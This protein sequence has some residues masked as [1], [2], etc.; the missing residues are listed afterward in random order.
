MLELREIT[1]AYTTASLTQTAL[2]QVSV[3]FRDNEFVAILGQSGSGKTT[4]LNVIGGLDHFDSGDLVIDGISTRD[5]KNRDW[6]TYR[7][8]RIG[9]VFQ[10]YNLIPHQTVLSNVEL[11]LTLSGVG[12]AERQSRAKDALT[13]VGLA[14]HIHKKPNQLSGGQMQRVAIARALVNDPEI[15]LADEP[16]GAL[17]SSTSVQVMDLL[18]EV[19][20][21]RLVIMVTHNPELAHR[22]ATRIVELA[23]GQIIADTAPFIPGTEEMRVAREARRT[24]MSFLTALSLSFTNLMTKKGRTLMTSF[25]GSIGIIGI[26]AILALANG[27]NAY[28]DRTEE[29]ML[30]SYPLVIRR[31]NVDMTSMLGAFGGAQG[32]NGDAKNAS[33]TQAKNGA[34]ADGAASGGL[35]SSNELEKVLGS[36]SENDLKALRTYFSANGGN[37]DEQVRAIEYNYDVTPQIYLPD[38]GKGKEPER[39]NPSSLLEDVKMPAG[40]PPVFSQNLTIEAF[41]ELPSESA[42][43]SEDYIVETGRWPDKANELV[44]VL[45]Q[46]GEVSDV[47]EFSLGLRDSKEIQ[48]M[49]D[50]SNKDA[51]QSDTQAQSADGQ[52]G[53]QSA[54]SAQS[55]APRKY[56]YEDILAVEYR[57][58]DISGFYDWDKERGIWADHSD[59][60]KRTADLVAKGE[61]LNIV[62]IMRTKPGVDAPSLQ[63]GLYYTDKLTEH[64][65]SKAAQSKIV[66]EQR[67]NPKRNV[68]TGKD[69]PQSASSDPLAGFDMA[70]LFTID[71]AKIQ[72][73]FSIDEAALS[74]A[75]GDID[76]SGM[77]LSGLE[78]I[79]MEAPAMDLSSLD[80]S[81]IDL[82]KVNASSVNADSL[83]SQ[84]PQLSNVDWNKTVNDA[85]ADGAIKQDAGPALSGL[86]QELAQGFMQYQAANT[87]SGKDPNALAVEY[88]STEPVTKRIQEVLSGPEVIDREKIGAN[89][90]KSLGNDPAVQAAGDAV[91][92]QIVKVLVQEVGTYV[93]DTISNAISSQIQQMM[94]AYMGQMMQT[95]EQEISAQMEKAAANMGE[96][97]TG[98]MKVDEKAISE[99]FSMNKEGADLTAIFTSMMSAQRDSYESN[100]AKLGYAEVENPST[101]AIYPHSF[102]AKE[103][104][105]TILADYN[106]AQQDAGYEK[107]V[108]Q[109][110]DMVGLVMSQV[111]NIVGAVTSMLIAFVGISLVVSS[112]MIGII[113]YIS[114][115]ERKKEIGILRSIGASRGDIRSVFNAETVLIG[116]LAGL[117]GVVITYLL[118]IPANI[119]VANILNIENIAQ[120]PILAAMLL[121]VISVG[122]TFMAGLLPAG[123]AAK[124]D[125]VEALRSE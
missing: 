51:A 42:I 85:L 70:S 14:D 25:A 27:V 44:L 20:K 120:L 113:T 59:D 71:E 22:Y 69:F 29:E 66:Q 123:K 3:A 31:S 67:K 74:E 62:G 101:I 86:S 65:M 121:I 75:M 84:F 80:L 114:V 116:L 36:L 117:L 7:N 11:A 97:F 18:K 40:L 26:A 12:R 125:P 47:F 46:D 68:F 64:V 78:S 1:K 77:D 54:E 89:L 88:F 100:L 50:A 107:R 41:S 63:A 38:R 76:L 91:A 19:A 79:P 102:Q 2:N 60:K 28:I 93:G 39:V 92:D 45:P 17:D 99:A 8:N 122:L 108:I 105:K 104:V 110:N 87:G 61:K 15:L 90:T 95:L 82:S 9:F 94:T 4:M 112:I 16:T 96:A 115:L 53:S 52:S 23:D 72:S 34:G 6:D 73:A 43:Y 56:T 98:A 55:V 13:R 35:T 5:F 83:Q 32:N 106:S 30:N 57:L 111:T 103:N 49:V 48:S 118:T 10:S 81:N 58:V 124:S 33:D 24:S 119:I 21:D 109:Y 37:I